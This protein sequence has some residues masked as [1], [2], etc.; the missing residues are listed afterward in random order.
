M[1][2]GAYSFKEYV[3]SCIGPKTGC[4]YT[5]DYAMIFCSEIE[6]GF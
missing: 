1:D 5:L 3:I 4:R 2:I 6:Y